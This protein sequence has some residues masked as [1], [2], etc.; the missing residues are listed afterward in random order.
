MIAAIKYCEFKNLNYDVLGGLP[1]KQFIEKF[2]LNKTFCFFPK[3]PE[4]LSR[5]VV[6]ARMMNM[7]VITNKTVGAI[8]EPWYS[9]KGG[10]LIDVMIKKRQEIINKIEKIM[11]S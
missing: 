6:E 11:S 10:A 1:Y 3:T 9:L 8:Y 4:T 2:G 7:G 5:L